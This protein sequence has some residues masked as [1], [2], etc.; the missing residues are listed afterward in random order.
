MPDAKSRSAGLQRRGENLKTGTLPAY[1]NGRMNYFFSSNGGKG[2]SLGAT[3]LAVLLLSPLGR[4][5]IPPGSGREGVV[6]TANFLIDHDESVRDARELGE[7]LESMAASFLEQAAAYSLPLNREGLAGLTL[8]WRFRA[9]DRDGRHISAWYDT[10]TQRVEFYRDTKAIAF[11]GRNP[12]YAPADSLPAEDALLTRMSHELT[13]QLAYACGLQKRG[14]M[15]PLWAAEGLATNYE[16]PSAAPRLFGPNPSRLKRLKR[17]VEARQLWPLSELAVATDT[18]RLDGEERIDLY[19][20]I[21]GLFRF[22]AVTRAPDLRAYFEQ[23]NRL[24][25]GAR[26]RDTLLEEFTGIFGDA[27]HLEHDWHL[28]LQNLHDQ[29]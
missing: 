2:L 22:L 10:R 7:S 25:S 13:H 14:V 20:Q 26:N 12:A 11:I 18:R 17:T 15:Y 8:Q 16:S 1:L 5:G 9:A 19:A 6:R 27:E 4:G 3:V 28:W 29:G 24:P 23:L 21:W